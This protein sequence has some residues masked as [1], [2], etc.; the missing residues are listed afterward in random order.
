MKEIIASGT[1]ISGENHLWH[2]EPVKLNAN[3]TEL[4]A[5]TARDFLK[6]DLIADTVLTGAQLLAYKYVTNQ[7]ATGEVDITLPAVSYPI[8]VIFI[9]EM[10]LV[11]EIN[12]PS[13][14]ILLLDGTALTADYVVDSPGAVG[15]KLIATRHQEA[16]GA[17]QWSVDAMTGVWLDGGVTD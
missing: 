3:F 9:S 4:Y 1:P 10:A 15:D 12:P 7:A 13:G 14:E 2:T 6:L 8:E 5:S 16:A 17:W 11:M